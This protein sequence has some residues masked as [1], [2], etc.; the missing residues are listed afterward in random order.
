MVEPEVEKMGVEGDNGLSLMALMAIFNKVLSIYIHTCTC[1]SQGV[2]TINIYF[3][4]SPLH[5]FLI[6]SHTQVNAQQVEMDKKFG[7]VH[8]AFAMLDK[9]SH[10][11]PQRLREQ[12]NTA[13]HRLAAEDLLTGTHST[14]VY[15]S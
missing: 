15:F 4:P 8:R 1:T 9:F 6:F 7:A 12:F 3:P 14:I 13:P 5:L 2:V 11:L 10:P